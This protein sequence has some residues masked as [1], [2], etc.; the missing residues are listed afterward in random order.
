[1]SY[2]LDALRKAE[3]DRDLGR[4]PGIGSDHEPAVVAIGGRWM[5]AVLIVLLVNAALLTFALW[6]ESAP[7]TGPVA[8]RE[9]PVVLE[10]R[11][12]VPVL[13][14]AALTARSDPEVYEPP[15]D[16]L[17]W[18]EP[19]VAAVTD[20]APPVELRPLPESESTPAAIR[21]R[22]A[23]LRPLPPLPESPALADAEPEQAA[24]PDEPDAPEIVY[25]A[26]AAPARD[27]NLPVWPQVSGQLFNEINSDLH[28]DV[29]VYSDRPQERFVLINMLKYGEG[30]R[31]Q[32]G[33]LVDAIT[34]DGVVL[35]FRGQR[36]RM[37]SQ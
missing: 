31:L 28:L 16:S 35:S 32:E 9:D 18:Q 30:E 1:M 34:P 25:Q 8:A 7:D 27:D 3:H 24:V 5:W 19:D 17:S 36:F 12:P 2:I 10:P 13:E 20:P 33:P 23:A 29:H 14:T 6:P 4:V 37:R 26:A 11:Q 15:E 21:A 22:A